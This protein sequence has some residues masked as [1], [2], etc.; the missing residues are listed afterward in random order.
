MVDGEDRE[1]VN[2]ANGPRDD[3]DPVGWEEIP[4]PDPVQ[5]NPVN[6]ERGVNVTVICPLCTNIMRLKPARRGG[7]FYGCSEWPACNGY[8]NKDGARPGPVATVTKLRN[9]F[10]DAAWKEME[11]LKCNGKFLKWHTPAPNALQK[12]RFC[13][14]DP[15]DHVGRNCPMRRGP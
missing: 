6:E 7:W 15:C 12:C 10:G 14:M 9:H 1:Q 3:A 4:A 8:R 2:E 11:E 13:G 5:N